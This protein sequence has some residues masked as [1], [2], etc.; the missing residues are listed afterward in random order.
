VDELSGVPLLLLPL[1]QLAQPGEVSL[2]RC[3]PDAAFLVFPVRRDPLL[4]HRVH[5]LGADLDLERNPLVA[6]DRGVQRLI[7][8]RPR[9]GDEVLEPTRHRR[10]GLVDNAQ[11][12]V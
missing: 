10:P 11:R 8:V 1:E 6:D 2:V 5:L 9:H 7:P 3:D 12:R 4:G